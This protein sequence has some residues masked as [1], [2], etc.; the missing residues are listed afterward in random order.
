MITR[1]GAEGFRILLAQSHRDIHVLF[2]K[3]VIHSLLSEEKCAMQWTWEEKEKAKIN[4]NNNTYVILLSTINSDAT[5][6]LLQKRP[7]DQ[8]VIINTLMNNATH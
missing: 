3:K 8:H 6:A 1:G 7:R 5:Q 2:L 4:N